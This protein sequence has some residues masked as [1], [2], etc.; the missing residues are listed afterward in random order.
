MTSLAKVQPEKPAELLHNLAETYPIPEL[1]RAATLFE[2][3][4]RLYEA[5]HCVRRQIE[6]ELTQYNNLRPELCRQKLAEKGLGW[7]TR[8]DG[9]VPLAKLTLFYFKD[10]RDEY[11]YNACVRCREQAFIW[12][13]EQGNDSE[14]AFDAYEVV[15]RNGKY[16]PINDIVP[17]DQFTLRAP[18]LSTEE[19]RITWGIPPEVRFFD[20]H[21]RKLLVNNAQYDFQWAGTRP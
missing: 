16:Y 9:T 5:L 17:L 8:H 1:A 2:I 20:S 10:S 13:A 21:H 7:C 3:E 19:V 4:Q 14:K 18:Y 6:G 12:L 15:E 11:I